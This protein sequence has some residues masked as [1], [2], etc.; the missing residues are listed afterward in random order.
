MY[1]DRQTQHQ[2]STDL[3]A[4]LELSCSIGSESSNAALGRASGIEQVELGFKV[5]VLHNNSDE[6]F[7]LSADF[8]RRFCI[9]AEIKT[10]GEQVG[11]GRSIRALET[12]QEPSRFSRSCEI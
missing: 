10:S 2:L 12:G 11:T 8:C 7:I 3:A 6:N 5:G 4:C 1:G 9:D